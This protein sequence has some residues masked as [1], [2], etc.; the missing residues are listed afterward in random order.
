MKDLGIYIHIPFCKSKCFYCDFYSKPECTNNNIEEYIDTICMELLAN[1]E[2]LQER[3][4]TTVYFG[5]GTPS[6]I[7]AKHI[8]KILDII[9][10]FNNSI[11]EITIEANPE[12]LNKE[13]LTA[14][15]EA[16]VNRLSLGLQSANDN[17]LKKIGRIATKEMF[18]KAY[19]DAIEAGFSNISTD[20]IIGLPDETLEDFKNTVEYILSLDKIKHISAYSLEVHEGTKLDFLLN[21]G[22]LTLP[23][24]NNEREMKYTLDKMLEEKGFNKYEISNYAKPKYESKHNTGYWNQQEYLGLGA[25]AASFINSTRY[26][27][28]PDMDKYIE[29]IKQGIS[30]KQDVE[31]M[32][33]L[34]TMKEYIILRLRLKEGLN[35]NEFKL[36]FKKDVLDMYKVQID[37]LVEEGLLEKDD[38]GIRLTYKG[39]DLA[40]IV[41]QEFI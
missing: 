32:D 20:V 17:T 9:R 29:Y 40:N 26:T 28:I 30:V 41:W 39:E 24:E 31:E 19:M 18:E 27:N 4:I 12:S 13:K 8:A 10:L 22:F 21:S 15:L 2:L 36:K 3:N 16:G 23:D 14:Y 37:K 38:K 33:L 11:E 34:D 25:A 1:S 5:G 6:L 35:F 7:D